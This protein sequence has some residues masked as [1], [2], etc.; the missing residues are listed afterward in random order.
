MGWGVSLVSLIWIPI[1]AIHEIYNNKG[2]F[3]SV[4]IGRMYGIMTLQN[5]LCLYLAVVSDCC[6]FSV[7]ARLLNSLCNPFTETNFLFSSPYIFTCSFDVLCS[8]FFSSSINPHSPEWD[9]MI[10][11]TVVFIYLLTSALF[12]NWCPKQWDPQGHIQFSLLYE[13]LFCT[14]NIMCQ[15]K[16]LKVVTS[17]GL[18]RVLSLDQNSISR[19][20]WFF[21]QSFLRKGFLHCRKSTAFRTPSHPV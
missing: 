5:T 20:Q 1:G 2:S 11:S 15:D 7:Q 21:A 8:V 3:L 16:N 14:Q 10:S 4:S 6:L 13:E 18:D 17:L 9:F 19:A 12:I